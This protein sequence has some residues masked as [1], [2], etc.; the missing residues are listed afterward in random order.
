MELVG[1]KTTGTSARYAHLSL[2]YKP[3]AVAQLPSLE[4]KTDSSGISP[5]EGGQ[6]CRFR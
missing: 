4:P 1:H 5:Q 2:D 3:Q 6:S